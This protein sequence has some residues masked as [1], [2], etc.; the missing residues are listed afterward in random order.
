MTTTSE[1]P[2]HDHGWP[3]I[4]IVTPSL[5]Q[6]LFLERTIESVLTQ[7]YENYEYFVFDA[8]S[9]DE[10]IEVLKKYDRELT[11]WTSER[12]GGQSDAIRRGWSLATGEI[13]AWLN[14]DDFYFPNALQEAA[15]MFAS[16]PKLMMLCGAVALVDEKEKMLRIKEPPPLDAEG[17]LRWGNLP[18]QPG[19]FLRREVFERL[20]GPRLDL[21]Y[22]MDWELWLRVCLTFPPEAIGF[23]NR[24]LAGDRQWS[25]TKT[26]NAR[27]ADAREVR[28][29]LDEMFS[30]LGVAHRYGKVQ[31]PALARAWWRQSKGE[32]CHGLRRCALASLAKAVLL[33]PT[34]FDPFKVLRQA[35]RILFGATGHPALTVKGA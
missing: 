18:A 16:N 22:V 33:C 2:A 24:L 8:G 30:D 13:L 5:N 28:K 31:R 10:T 23:T 6:G 7:G 32:L 9:Q 19:V 20:G 27:G 11:Y 1:G 4:S 15:A 29:V 21:H 3:K 14:S 35:R 25:G 17:L 34:A 12:D 26:L